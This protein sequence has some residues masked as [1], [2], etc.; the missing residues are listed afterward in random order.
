MIDGD[1]HKDEAIRQARELFGSVVRDQQQK[2]AEQDHKIRCLEEEI[3]QL[4]HFSSPEETLKR[5]ELARSIDWR[6]IPVSD[7]EEIRRKMSGR[8][9]A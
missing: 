3:R 6:Y 1:R 2:I 9:G 7:L 4:K 8:S 5:I